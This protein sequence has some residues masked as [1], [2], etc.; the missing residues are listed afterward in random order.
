MENHIKYIIYCTFYTIYPIQYTIYYPVAR[1]TWGTRDRA[2]GQG[3]FLPLTNF[4]K[5]KGC[6]LS[7]SQKKRGSTMNEEKL[8]ICVNCEENEVSSKGMILC[9]DCIVHLQPEDQ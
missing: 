8:Q 1:G 2:G 9:D 4:I 3:W 7:A 6:L 5:D